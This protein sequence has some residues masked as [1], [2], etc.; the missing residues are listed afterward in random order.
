MKQLKVN[1]TMKRITSFL[2]VPI[3]LLLSLSSKAEV[4]VHEWEENVKGY[5]MKQIPGTS[6]YIAAGTYHGDDNG[7]PFIGYHF[8]HM[9]DQGT[10]LQSTTHYPNANNYDKEYRVIDIVPIDPQECWVILQV[11]DFDYVNAQGIH[12][13]LDYVYAERVEIS[14]GLK[15]TKMPSDFSILH[16][17]DGFYGTSAIEYNGDIFISG[18]QADLSP[19]GGVNLATLPT[20]TSEGKF[21][22]LMKVHLSAGGTPPTIQVRRWNTISG[23]FDYDMALK[24]KP[25]NNG[26]LLVVGACNTANVPFNNYYYSGINIARIEASTL[27]IVSNR[28]LHFSTGY[29][30]PGPIDRGAYGIDVAEGTDNSILVLFNSFDYGSVLNFG[31]ARVESDYTGGS[32]SGPNDL[33]A[34]TNLTN[35]V[36][37][38]PGDRSAWGKQIHAE[39]PLSTTTYTIYGEVKALYAGFAGTCTRYPVSNAPSI[40]NIDPFV[41]SFGLHYNP[42]IGLVVNFGDMIISE[43]TLGTTTTSGLDYIYPSASVV[44]TNIE[45]ITRRNSFF[46]PVSGSNELKVLAPMQNPSNTDYLNAKFLDLIS[47][48]EEIYCGQ[49]IDLTC[50]PG[51]S[52]GT[53]ASSEDDVVYDPL[54]SI[55]DYGVF[56]N[57]INISHNLIVHVGAPTTYDCQ[58]A[59][60]NHNGYK[61]TSVANTEDIKGIDLYPNPATSELNIKV[62]AAAGDEVQFVLTDITGK[63]VLNNTAKNNGNIKVQLPNLTPGLY[64]G[65]VMVGSEQYTEKI[66]IE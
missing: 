11:R 24:V 7:T 2:L 48:G 42:N 3:L 40:T 27:N 14:T 32:S 22:L 57:T 10:V 65:T 61:P 20:N 45:D 25:S 51:F 55:Q 50:S 31:V 26:S 36:N 23:H 52:V 47:N 49:Y 66:I 38:G 41:G 15:S 39:N 19:G 17:H 58:D 8:M 21:S 62:N 12:Y 1:L 64:I 30:Y 54:V 9:D 37:F 4:T 56:T 16:D 53:I 43:S 60:N 59:I 63:E 18:Y 13:M 28:I 46:V 44:G 35:R 33:Y 34:N 29:T 5:S 6:E